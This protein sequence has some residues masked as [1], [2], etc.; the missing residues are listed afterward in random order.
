[1]KQPTV[2]IDYP[3]TSLRQQCRY[4]LRQLPHYIRTYILATFPIIQWIYR[5]NLS[6][7]LQDMIAG[8]TV[9]IVIVPQGMAYAKLAN[10]DPQYG[11]YTSFVGAALYCFFGTSKD[12]SIGPIS[13]VSLLVGETVHMVTTNYPN[14]TGPEIGVTLALFSGIILVAIGIIRLGLIVDFIPG[15]AI[16]GF[17]TGSAI[18][19]VLSQ[20]PALTGIGPEVDTHASPFHVLIDFITNLPHTQLDI[21][22]GL[23]GLVLLYLIRF[24]CGRLNARLANNKS[25][26]AVFYFGIM[27]NGL[28]VFLGTLISFLISIGRATTPIRVIAA[29]PAGFDAMGVPGLNFEVIR[30]ASGSLPSII[31]ILILEH[32]SVAKSFGRVSNYTIQPNQ[33]ILAIG[34]SNVVGSFFGAYPATGAFSRTAIMSRSGA[35]TPL[36]GMFSAAVVVLALYALTPAFYYIPNAILSAV[37][38]HAV[39]DLVSGPTYLREVWSANPIEFCIWLVT[40]IVTFFLDIETGLYIAIGLSLAT[41]LFQLARPQV[42]A[43]VRVQS[44]YYADE[45]DPNFSKRMESLPSGLLVMQPVDSILYP[46]AEHISEVIVQTI[47]TRTRNGICHGEISDKDRPWNAEQLIDHGGRNIGPVLRAIVLDMSAVR[48]IDS[49][50]LQMLVSLQKTVL[51]YTCHDVEWHFTNLNPAVRNK[52]LSFGFGRLSLKNL[53]FCSREPKDFQQQQQQQQVDLE[54]GTPGPST[55]PAMVDN[56]TSSAPVDRYIAFHWDVDTAV[57]TIDH[58][59]QEAPRSLY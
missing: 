35:R 38:I 26:K 57:Q 3:P 47:K 41:V 37:V 52:L 46:N 51:A 29:V 30:V 2:V 43:L 16:A 48:R 17:M 6:W 22:F 25:R 39:S 18:T 28:I 21:A 12:I 23:V 27:R 15:P 54:V 42:N 45:R 5:Y 20:L 8:V 19:I 14:I 36:A 31:L 44:H 1:M 11:L 53:S 10:L 50:G 59:W 34:I 4:H 55:S 32:V 7:L 24:G 56:S 13:T 49:T 9:G 33:E 40:V 58:R